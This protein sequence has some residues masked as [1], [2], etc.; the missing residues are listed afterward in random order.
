[1][2]TFVPHA[3][4]C[5][6]LPCLA[7]AGCGADDAPAAAAPDATTAPAPPMAEKTTSMPDIESGMVDGLCA[8]GPGAEGADSYFT[9]TLKVSGGAVTG[10]ESWVL[11]ANPKWQARGGNDCRLIWDVKG[12]VV[13][14]SNCTACDLG[15]KFSAVP[16]L[17][18]S[19]PEE[20]VQGRKLATGQRVG[21]EGVAFDQ[22]YSVQRMPDGKARVFF[23]KSGKLLGEGYHAG[24]TVQWLS[25][26]SCKWF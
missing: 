25:S 23:G 3:L 10:S 20:L 26:H 7:L 22:T 9:G 16:R 24:G 11:F 15:V 13:P 4:L 19:C 12:E 21:G 18:S 2:R 17:D 14:P 5:L 1:M 8:N 6:G